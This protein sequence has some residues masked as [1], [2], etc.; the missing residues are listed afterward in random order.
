[1]RV[2]CPENSLNLN[3]RNEDFRKDMRFLESD[4]FVSGQTPFQVSDSNNIDESSE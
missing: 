1:M 4:G 3:L 2:I